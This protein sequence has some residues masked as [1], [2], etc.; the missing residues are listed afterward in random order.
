MLVLASG[1]PRR[2]S[3]LGQ[4]GL[5]P[6]IVHPAD[7]D[8]APA[9]QEQPRELACRLAQQKCDAVAAHFERQGTNAVILAADTVVACGRR[10]L[11]KAEDVQE[12]R[13]CLSLLSG[14]AHRVY[15]GVSVAHGSDR[16]TRIVETRVIF[17][18]IGAR[19]LENYL[20][21]GEW[22]GKAGAYGIQGKAAVF[23]KSINGSY[24][25]VVGLPLRET[26]HLLEAAGLSF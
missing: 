12:A 6:D 19:Q 25:N 23:V 3:L 8:E 9:P 22:Q 17:G 7:I 24:S 21:S 11:P 4:I 20:Q 16:W 26:A 5:E 15:T 2:L 14:R 13:D 18:R 10:V 1:S